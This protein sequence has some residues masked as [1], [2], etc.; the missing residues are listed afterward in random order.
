MTA[1]HRYTDEGDDGSGDDGG[2]SRIDR[3]ANDRP[4]ER[5]ENDRE[6][7]PASVSAMVGISG[8]TRTCH[9]ETDYGSLAY[10]SRE[11]STEA[12]LR[13]LRSIN[14]VSRHNGSVP[15]FGPRLQPCQEHRG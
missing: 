1:G 14:H 6:T 5:V 7:E 12:A 11:S 13:E 4:A 2:R 8:R 15:A 9:G 3:P 10:A